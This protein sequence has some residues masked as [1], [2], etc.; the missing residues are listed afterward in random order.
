M[1]LADAPKWSNG[2]KTVTITLKS[3]YK[4][5]DGKPIT[6]QDV[7]FW[8]DMMKAAIKESPANWA[9]YTPGLG[10]PDQL[11]S[12]TTPNSKT[13]VI[14]LKTAVQPVVVHP[15]QSRGDPAHAQPR[16][17]QGLGKRPA[18]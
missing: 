14:N 13:L 1:S 8:I 5:S 3:D 18:R 6:S 7:L 15:G 10:I 11:A 16:V 12:T 9:N 4:W 17:G 2:N